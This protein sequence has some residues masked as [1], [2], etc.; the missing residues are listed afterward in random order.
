M[1]VPEAGGGSPV[2]DLSVHGDSSPGYEDYS[3]VVP[4]DRANWPTV[5]VALDGVQSV[6]EGLHAS[7]EL[8]IMHENSCIHADSLVDDDDD[9]YTIVAAPN[10]LINC[11]PM[12]TKSKRSIYKP[13]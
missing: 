1:H 2:H 10:C 7:A 8:P 13:K 3:R 4:G 6:S 5:D 12:I 11:H 9:A